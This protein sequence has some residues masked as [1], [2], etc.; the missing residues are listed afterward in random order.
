MRSDPWQSRSGLERNR[1]ATAGVGIIL[2]DDHPVPLKAEARAASELLGLDPL[3]AVCDGRFF[4]ICPAAMRETAEISEVCARA[5]GFVE[6]RTEC[7]G[8][9]IGDW[10]AGDLMP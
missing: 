1:A 6:M 10:L 4:G 9:P 7:A 3:Y 5:A 2:L 8:R